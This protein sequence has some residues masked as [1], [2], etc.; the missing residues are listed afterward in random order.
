M[1]A[2]RW[3]LAGALCV[4][5]GLGVAAQGQLARRD[6]APEPVAQPHRTRLIL[7]D[8]SYQVIGS[9]KVVGNRVQYTSAERGGEMEEIPLDLVDL[10]AT[11][12][13]AQQHTVAEGADG[14]ES[15]PAPAI[16]PELL[17]EEADRLALTPEVATDLR[18]PEEDSVVAMDTWQATPE[19]VP[20]VQSQGELNKQTGHSVTRGA[21]NPYSMAHQMVVLKGEKADVQMHVDQPE[22]FVRL[23]DAAT[24]G[25]GAITVDTHGASSAIREEKKGPPHTY[26]IVRTDVRQDARVIAS[27]NLAQLGTGAH[28]ED[29]FETQATALPGGHW[30]K[31]VPRENLLVGEYALVE[32]LSD[33]AI[34][35]GVWEFGVHPRAPENRDAVL[36]EKRRTPVLGRRQ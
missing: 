1:R 21:V 23:D 5:V 15:R 14:Q 3:V 7:K 19:L 9:Y 24:S 25:G 36:P 18:L 27:F 30:L 31:L 20:L 35:V 13:W 2:V 28:Q 26:V 16:D 22:I 8:G 29:V 11:K 4:E 33:K 10:A 12:K 34:N 6:G 32:V 17:K